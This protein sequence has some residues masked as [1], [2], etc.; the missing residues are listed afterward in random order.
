M[1]DAPDVRP[2]R[3]PG[4]TAVILAAGASS[5]MG[6]DVPKQFLEV[7]GRSLLD[8][9]IHAFSGL[10]DE[11]IVTV[12]EGLAEVIG[13]ADPVTLVTG[14]Q[15]RTESVR[16]ALA[17]V[18]F[19]RVLVHDAAR[20]FVTSAV[21]DEIVASL[22]DYDCAYP[23]MPVV[24][25][26]VVDKRG[27]LVK[28]PKRAKFREVQTPQGFRTETLETAIDRFGEKHAHLPELVRKLG[29]PV[30]HTTGSPWLFKLTYAPSLQIAEYYV[31]HVEPTV[32]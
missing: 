31:D 20:P 19:D 9:A 23:V 10:V 32:S 30:K 24:N 18:S 17:K 11:I 1:R 28:S 2:A 27:E 21:I 3:S 5:R 13:V 29:K 16:R 12:P 25:S 8:R 14:G 6:A 22:D 7:G 26:L 4:V 15:T